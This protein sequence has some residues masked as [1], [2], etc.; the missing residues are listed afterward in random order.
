MCVFVFWGAPFSI[1]PIHRSLALLSFHYACICIRTQHTYIYASVFARSITS[2]FGMGRMIWASVATRRAGSMTPVTA[3]PRR[4]AGGAILLPSVVQ[5][6]THCNPSSKLY[7]ST[8]KTVFQTRKSRNQPLGRLQHLF[9][10]YLPSSVPRHRVIKLKTVTIASNMTRLAHRRRLESPPY[11]II[12]LFD[13]KIYCSTLLLSNRINVYG[14]FQC[15]LII[16]IAYNV[17][18]FIVC[19]RQKKSGHKSI[20][21]CTYKVNRFLVKLTIEFR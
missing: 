14:I 12:S 17:S 7:T 15:S 13:Q 5:Q 19:Q 11:T 4:R 1:P 20:I 6:H 9:S 21:P 3:W 2:Q 10:L 8:T 18:N 16:L